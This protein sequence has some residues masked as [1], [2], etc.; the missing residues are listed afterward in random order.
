M[1]ISLKRA[2]L[3][4]GAWDESS[5]LKDAHKKAGIP[6]GDERTMRRNRRWTEDL[7]GIELAAHNDK[8][9]THKNIECPSSLDIR[10]ARK[11]K[12]FVITSLTNNSPVIKPFLAALKKFIEARNGQLLVI[13]VRYQNP[14][15]MHTTKGYFWDSAIYP[16]A[17]TED[18]SLGKNLMVSAV[19][20]NATSVNP[21]SGKQALG[22]HKSVVYGH[23]QLAMELVGTPKDEMPKV[24]MTTGSCNR[25]Q[26]T[27]S[28]VGGKANFYHTVTPYT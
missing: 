19:R 12:D 18:L 5:S 9:S 17:L 20:L 25:S 6:A 3:L 8:Y 28:D 2:N 4:A 15:A 11:C 21:L 14:N 7:L 26:Y 1:G 10:E 24:M 22:G 16:Y 13:P 27:S 23:P